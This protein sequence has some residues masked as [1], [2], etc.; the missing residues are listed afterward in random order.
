M[1]IA[2]FLLLA[3]G[4]VKDSAAPCV[5]GTVY[6][7][8]DA[9]GHGDP[10]E[11]LYA[12]DADP[13]VAPV[14]DDCDDAD[15]DGHGTDTNATPSCTQPA[16]YLASALDC[17]DT[18]REVS[19]EADERCDGYDNN[20]DGRVDEDEAVDAT[21]WYLDADRDGAGVPSSTY[22]ACGQ[23][24]GYSANFLDCDDTS[25]DVSPTAAE[26][27]DGR[28]EDCDG[29]IDP[30]TA[31]DA[32]TW[33]LDADADGAGSPVDGPTQCTGPAGYVRSG[34]DCDDTE[35]LV[36]PGA[37][38]RWNL[39]DD[40]CDGIVDD[41][42]DRTWVPPFPTERVAWLWPFSADS[43]WNTSV[44]D[45]LTLEDVTDPCTL[46]LR[47]TEADAWINAEEW[48][49]PVYLADARD[50]W[51]DITEEG[52]VVTSVRSPTTATPSLP[53]WPEGDA[54]LHLVDPAGTLVTEL[55]EAHWESAGWTVS[56]EATVDLYGT[57]V[58][59]GGVRI[60]GGSAFAGLM[61]NGETETGIWHAL[62]VS[63]PLDTLS[64]TYTWP[65]ATLSTTR[66]SSMLG[67]IPIGQHIALPPDVDESLVTTPAGLAV[68]R[69]LRDYGAYVVDHA[70][71]FALYAE[72]TMEA[73]IDPAR[74]DIETL[75]GLLRCST[76]V[77]E[78]DPG[79]P[80]LRT[81]PNAPALP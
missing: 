10:S 50:P 78:D 29:R 38:E 69:A 22:A 5:P 13:G 31:V 67:P 49:H 21:T 41:S 62:A 24:S 63:L 64:P 19:P 76:N 46:A 53:A 8:A 52:S 18:D 30:D 58:G 7:D 9:D 17:D 44:G 26:T 37:L 16:G 20:C 59:S 3:C 68:L 56:S 57:G 54:H 77:T 32:P 60:Y 47:S 55:W 4:S 70:G 27:C 11:P 74:D 45:G 34:D 15:R 75:V 39:I 40:D 73:E 71:N 80:G 28:D 2:L 65:A 23:P 36:Y 43:A 51:V 12:C 25:P 72:P 6:V 66:E 79:G 81:W 35:P 33:H 61:R 48:S 42:A 1:V 14:G